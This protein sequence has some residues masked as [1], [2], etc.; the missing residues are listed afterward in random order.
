MKKFISIIMS[1]TLFGIIILPNQNFNAA[2]VS[3]TAGIVSTTSTSLNV[4]S[5][6]ST[7]SPVVTSL[8]KGSYVTLISK[9]GQWWYIEYGNGKYGYCHSDYIKSVS[10]SVSSVNIQSG[11]LNVRSGAGTAY[12]V[13]DT[14]SKG[15]NVLVL[16]SSNGWSKILYNGVKTGYVSDKYLQATTYSKITLNVPNF[17]QTDSRWANVKIGNSGKTIGQ[18]GCTTTA[19]A[20]IESYK[21]GTIIYPD[22][23]S[24]K[25]SYSSSGDL[26][27]P[28]NY[29]V[30]TDKSGYLKSIYNILK[31]GKPVLF[32]AKNSKGSQH[33]VIITGYN[34]GNALSPSDFK[35][36]DPG[37]NTRINLQQF[38]N[39]YP[40]FYKYF[41]YK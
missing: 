36:N 29:Q 39:S 33:W 32:G 9:S 40:N 41:Y 2:T 17:K 1:L 31:Q 23:M 7:S 24:K 30:V 27:W 6:S 38:L 26:Y 3:S 18:I 8:K 11:Y 14:L 25:L 21:N 34:G 22:A 4:R 13:K 37:S 28:S 20:M 19:I 10:S 35:I 15:K 5:G 16:S 12:S